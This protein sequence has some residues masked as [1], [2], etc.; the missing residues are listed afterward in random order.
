MTKFIVKIFSCF[1]EIYKYVAVTKFIHFEDYKFAEM[2]DFEE[3]E[4]EEIT[5]INC[6]NVNWFAEFLAKD[7]TRVKI[8]TIKYLVFSGHVI[9][10]F[11][12]HGRKITRI[13]IKDITFL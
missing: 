12:K 2:P 4:F 7:Q 8:L 9:Q 6:K 1:I 13:V 5:L 10:M 11:A 3:F